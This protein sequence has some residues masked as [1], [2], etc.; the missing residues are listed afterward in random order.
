MKKDRV[1]DYATEA[2]RDYAL[3]KSSDSI[4]ET[5][6]MDIAAV[7]NTLK[8]F[9]NKKPS[10]V[11]AVKA[12]YFT[13]AGV[14]FRKNTVMP[15]RSIPTKALCIVGFGR[16]GASLRSTADWLYINKIC[17]KVA[18][19]GFRFYDMLISEDGYSVSRFS[20]LVILWQCLR[21]S[22]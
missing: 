17:L 7:E 13:D 20:I 5:R 12:V 2:F 9:E 18:S 1:R 14:P 21:S 11:S 19:S 15:Y 8:Y 22:R 3:L 4:S 16:Q 6:R 10:V